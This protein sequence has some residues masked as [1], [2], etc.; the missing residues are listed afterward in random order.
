MRGMK[1]DFSMEEIL[2]R[3]QFTVCGQTAGIIVGLLLPAW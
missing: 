3:I 2:G 1:V